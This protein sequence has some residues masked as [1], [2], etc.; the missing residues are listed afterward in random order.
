MEDRPGT[1]IPSSGAIVNVI[2][3]HVTFDSKWIDGIPVYYGS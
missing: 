1:Q 3:N 2:V